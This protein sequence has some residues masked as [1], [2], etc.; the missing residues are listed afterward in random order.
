MDGTLIT[1]LHHLLNDDFHNQIA[2]LTRVISKLASDVLGT[3]VGNSPSVYPVPP[4]APID[5]DVGRLC[6]KRS[7][8]V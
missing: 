5:S 1:E 8:C 4:A 3:V 6:F 2:Q 7:D